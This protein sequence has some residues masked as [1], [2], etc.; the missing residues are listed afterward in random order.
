MRLRPSEIRHDAV[1]K[2]LRYEAAEALDRFGRNAVLRMA[3][4]Y[5]SRT[6]SSNG[7]GR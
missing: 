7:V 3:T 6:S 5:S 2:V 1:T 4:Q